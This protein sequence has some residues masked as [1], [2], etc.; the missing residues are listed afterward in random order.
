MDEHILTQMM[1][2]VSNKG[3]P[4]GCY[5]NRKGVTEKRRQQA[6]QQIERRLSALEKRLDRLEETTNEPK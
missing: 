3:L 6:M 2:G 1:E 4:P 5:I